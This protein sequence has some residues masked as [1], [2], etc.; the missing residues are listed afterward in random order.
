MAIEGMVGGYLGGSVGRG[1]V[2]AACALVSIVRIAISV[3]SYEY[4][5]QKPKPCKLLRQLADE[6]DSGGR[7]EK[8]EVEA[9][10]ASTASTSST[11]FF[12]L[13]YFCNSLFGL[14]NGRFLTFG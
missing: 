12:L 2:F 5:V 11:L 6:E 14:R 1:Y 10:I 4:S 13:F 8:R 9:S 7:R 3:C